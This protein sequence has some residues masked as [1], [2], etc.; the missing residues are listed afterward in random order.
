MSSIGELFQRLRVETRDV[1]TAND[2]AEIAEK[3]Q[4][5]TDIRASFGEEVANLE[6]LLT[7]DSEEMKQLYDSFSSVRSSYIADLETLIGFA[8]ANK[9]ADALALMQ[10]TMK[11]SAA[12]EM[13]AIDAMITFKREAAS[14]TADSNTTLSATAKII[15]LG[16]MGASILIAVLLGVFLSGMLSKPMKEM[17]AVAEKIA[18][19]DLNVDVTYHSK[20]E[21]GQL[22]QAFSKMIENLNGTMGNVRSSADQVAYGSRQVATSAQALSQG[23]TEQA[24]SVEE[25]TSSL[26]QISVQT[27]QNAERATEA[28]KIALMAKKRRSRGH[29]PHAGHAEGHGRYQ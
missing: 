8:E 18:N 23:A 3:E 16:V 11:E 22:A 19:D 13:N 20:D 24:S 25:L 29:R 4:N 15:M 14:E 26:E 9:D 10:G 21:I 5:I 2:A 17:V 27:Q 1:I 7:D 28:S 12:A 6:A